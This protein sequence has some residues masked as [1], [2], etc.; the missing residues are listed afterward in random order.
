[1]KIIKW[2]LGGLLVLIVG[3]ISVGAFLIFTFDPE[4]YRD[5]IEAEAFKATG[6]TLTLAGPMDLKISLS[7]TLVV[8]D[9]ILANAEWGSRAE[10]ISFDRLEFAAEL[11]PLINGRV[12]IS[13]LVLIGADILIETGTDGAGN[14]EFEPAETSASNPEPSDGPVRIPEGDGPATPGE[15]RDL[16]IGIDSLIIRDSF[17]TYL[18]GVTG[19]E[20]KFKITNLEASAPDL[21]S[22]ITLAFDAALDD[23]PISL[24][25][26]I[27]AIS[28]MTSAPFPIDIEASAGGANLSIKGEIANLMTAEGIDLDITLSGSELEKL[29]ELAGGGVPDLGAY[30]IRFHVSQSGPIYQISALAL[31]LAGS[32]IAGTAA[33][34]LDGRPSVTARLTSSLLD[35]PALTGSGGANETGG[36]TGG[37]TSGSSGN[38]SN[39]GAYVL[40]QDPIAF[41]ALTAADADITLSVT[42]LN[43]DNQLTADNA[44]LTLT[45][46]DG[47]LS[48]APLSFDLS[49]G[50]HIDLQT[51]INGAAARPPIA[52]TINGDNLDY[53]RLLAMY[54]EE[55][56]FAGTLNIDANLNGAG[57]SLHDIGASLNGPIEI[58]GE[59]GTIDNRWLK[60]VTGGITD[61]LGPLFGNQQNAALHC[62]LF[63]AH[64]QNGVI[65]ASGLALD[66]EVFTLFGG[67]L[68]DL[69]DESLDLSFSSGTSTV[70]ISS[71]VPPFNVTGT[72]SD[73]KIRPDVVGAVSGIARALGGAVN[74]QNVL[75]VFTGGD[76]SSGDT[77]SCARAIEEAAKPAPASPVD[78]VT[79]TV[80]TAVDGAVDT[81][82]QGLDTAIE[83]GDPGNIEDAAKDAVEGIRGL[84]GR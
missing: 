26:T 39:D 2:I 82:R 66:S 9:A 40:S 12:K 21:S 15:D 58:K 65:T 1:M 72:L 81:L 36:S 55:N 10:M 23:K 16:A 76:P 17:F 45:I 42:K 44:E 51:T 20:T 19:K 54:G 7:P 37:G 32:D 49:S 5:R 56:S 48:I 61:I 24:N 28:T 79:D 77:N 53:G 25:G 64:A 4:Q 80:G 75:S 6:R 38:N 27:G 60:L 11:L 31:A 59:N 70:A 46:T 34:S 14:W 74:P 30:D 52:V 73:P 8:E 68:I 50:G 57:A 41:D 22:P 71:L 67:G 83:T 13:K 78:A 33:I 35:I 63:D 43:L 69:R 84:F 29:N 47:N 62:I 18:D 3:L